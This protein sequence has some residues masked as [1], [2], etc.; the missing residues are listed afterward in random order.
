[1]QSDLDNLSFQEI[2]DLLINKRRQLMQ[3]AD[4]A[5]R[6]A[7]NDLKREIENIK[8]VLRAYLEKRTV[9]AN[10]LRQGL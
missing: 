7:I 8:E 1:M 9:H 2:S 4:D 3:L 5:N 6:Y 10:N